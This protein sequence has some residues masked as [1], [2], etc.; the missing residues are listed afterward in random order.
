MHPE[1]LG[2]A[3]L[4]RDLTVADAQHPRDVLPLHFIEGSICVVFRIWKDRR[5]TIGRFKG[6]GE[7]EH[8][9]GRDEDRPL[10]PRRRAV[11]W[12]CILIFILC[13]MPAPIEIVE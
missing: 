6:G 5:S 10:D 13:F 1:H 2:G 3:A 4:A 11:A 9:V 12:L 8:P 7:A